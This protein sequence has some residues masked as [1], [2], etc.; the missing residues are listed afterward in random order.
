MDIKKEFINRS[1]ASIERNLD[2]KLKKG[3][4]QE[5]DKTSTLSRI[6]TTLDVKDARSLTGRILDLAALK[7]IFGPV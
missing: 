7:E 4:I 5:S 6:T 2:R 3:T 1:L